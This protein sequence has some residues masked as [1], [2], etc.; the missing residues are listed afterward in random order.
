[1]AKKQRSRRNRKTTGSSKNNNQGEVSKNNTIGNEQH[2]PLLVDHYT[3]FKRSLDDCSLELIQD[4]YRQQGDT[5]KDI[6]PQASREKMEDILL[7]TTDLD[8]PFL[9]PT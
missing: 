2:Q 5:F 9:N 1:M 7:K 6:D 8:L 4:A 3:F